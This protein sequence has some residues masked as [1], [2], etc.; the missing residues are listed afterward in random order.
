MLGWLQHYENVVDPYHVPVLHG[1]FSGP[2]FTNMIASVPEVK[3]ETLPR[4]VTVRSIRNQ[5]DGKVFYRVTEAAL[6][7]LRLV[8][9]PRVAEFARV[10]SIG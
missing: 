7:T 1:S 5:D 3:F 10:G 2:Q 9:D 6:P 8:P 4:G